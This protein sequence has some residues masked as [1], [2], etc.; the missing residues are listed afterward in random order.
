MNANLLWQK[1]R[2]QEAQWWWTPHR[3]RLKLKL[4]PRAPGLPLCGS[5]FPATGPGMANGFGSGDIG[6][7]ARIRTL[8][9]LPAI[10]AGVTM[11]TSGL[12]VIGADL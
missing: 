2:L 7:H 10:G 11:A 1:A 12:K 6:R 4:F 9:G 8:F 5:G 3:R